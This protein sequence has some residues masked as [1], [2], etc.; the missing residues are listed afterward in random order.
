MTHH[1]HSPF[2]AFGKERCRI[3]LVGAHIADL[4]A[5]PGG[6]IEQTDLVGPY[7]D[8]DTW[9]DGTRDEKVDLILIEC[10]T[11]FEETIH[12]L[13]A[14]VAVAHGAR[15][16][17]VYNFAQTRALELAGKL[18]KTMTTMRA[19]VT[20]E[21]LKSACEADLALAMIRTHSSE[22]PIKQDSNDT[23]M[24]VEQ[25]EQIPPRQ[26]TDIQLSRIS[27]I[28]T[29]V[30]CECPHHLASILA[31]LNAFERYSRECENKH[32]GDATMHAFLHRRTA[33]ARAMMED[34]LSILAESE[35]LPI[36]D[37]SE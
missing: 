34:A 21:E 14:S 30:Q 11:L 15:V 19:P 18:A 29:A 7:P 24:P 23:G 16:I 10:P 31:E 32:P 4:L 17:I 28:S 9:A 13:N 5:G 3:T 22:H 35:G 26:F 20:A 27:K 2:S 1:E 37:A 6:L 33:Q 25:S 12:S 8:Y 36:G